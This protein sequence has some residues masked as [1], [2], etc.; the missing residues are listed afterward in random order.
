[1][2]LMEK[3]IADQQAEQDTDVSLRARVNNNILGKKLFD[4]YDYGNSVVDDIK[5]TSGNE[6][7]DDGRKQKAW[8]DMLQV[9]QEKQVFSELIYDANKD[10]YINMSPSKMTASDLLYTKKN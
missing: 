5:D 4:I 9:D 10:E 7:I 1:M 2:T 6:K 8:D 3:L